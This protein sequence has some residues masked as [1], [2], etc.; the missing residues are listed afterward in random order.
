[1]TKKNQMLLG[2][3]VVVGV[4]IY[5]YNRNKNNNGI[6]DVNSTMSN[7]DGDKIRKTDWECSGENRCPCNV[8]GAVACGSCGDPACVGTGSQ[9]GIG[10]GGRTRRRRPQRLQRVKRRSAI[11]R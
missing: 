11:R 7:A 10:S 4:G 6:T 1:M 9:L 5:L 2:A 3:V 8:V